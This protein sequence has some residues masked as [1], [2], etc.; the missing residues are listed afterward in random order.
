MLNQAIL[1]IERHVAA[2]GWDGPARLYALVD[3]AA[4]LREEPAL[5][6]QLGLDDVPDLRLP[7]SLTPVEQEE[8]PADEPLDE[9]LA[10]IVWGPAV[11]GCALSIERLMLPPQAEAGL[12]AA[13][14]DAAAYAAA[15]PEREDVRI[16]VG[17]LRDGTVDTVLRL[18]SQDRDD[19]VVFGPA[20][21]PGL[22]RALAATFED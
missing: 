20:L 11:D 12:P 9:V 3:T 10:G 15:H 17:V 1:E 21:V 7:T 16:V 6:T 2:S 14:E 4:L 8:F 18:R 22:A 5:A 19:A 13:D